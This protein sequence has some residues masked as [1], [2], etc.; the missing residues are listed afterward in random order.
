MSKEAGMEGKI[1]EG[2]IVE[3]YGYDVTSEGQD[4]ERLSEGELQMAQAEANTDMKQKN[5]T[6]IAEKLQKVIERE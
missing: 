5:S 1:E 6:E 3:G 2:K 4:G